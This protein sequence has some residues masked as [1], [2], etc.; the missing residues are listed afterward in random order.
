[1]TTSALVRLIGCATVREGQASSQGNDSYKVYERS[2]DN[3]YVL[4]IDPEAGRID[5]DPLGDRH[6]VQ[7]RAHRT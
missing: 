2:G 1:M 5:G 6:D 7:A 4:T 3:R